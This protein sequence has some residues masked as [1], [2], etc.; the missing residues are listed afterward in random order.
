[1]SIVGIMRDEKRG[2]IFSDG[3][4]SGAD[5]VFNETFSKLGEGPLGWA[6]CVGSLAEGQLGLKIFAKDKTTSIK[7]LAR[8]WREKMLIG[9]Y[10]GDAELL[11]ATVDG[12]SFKVDSDGGVFEVSASFAV[13]GSGAHVAHGY[14]A[15]KNVAVPVDYCLAD[16]IVKACA[17]V[18]LSVGGLS[19]D[20][21]IGPIKDYG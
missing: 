15:G 14:W 7:K 12:R 8:K 3:R 5:T 6:G 13:S 4:I 18:V 1:M 17:T 16:S 20:L 2:L 19:F 21:E 11:I 9:G 10:Q